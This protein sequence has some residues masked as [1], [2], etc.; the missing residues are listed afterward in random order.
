ME[1]IYSNLEVRRYGTVHPFVYTQPC[2]ST[3]D[4]QEHTCSRKATRGKFPRK[5]ARTFPGKR[6]Y[7]LVSQG[8]PNMASFGIY[9]YIEYC[10]QIFHE[11]TNKVHPTY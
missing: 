9:S 1:H 2:I 5:F 6:P 7:K 11:E 8:F 4:Q 3:P 10:C